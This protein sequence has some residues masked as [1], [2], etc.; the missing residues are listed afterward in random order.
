MSQPMSMLPTMPLDPAWLEQSAA[1]MHPDPRMAR[2]AMKLLFAAWRGSPAASVPNSQA[3]L[4]EVTGLPVELV[5]E[6]LESLT[7]GYELRGDGRLHHVGMARICEQMV[8]SYGPQIEAFS[9][10]LAMTAQDPEQF[11]L[12]SVEASR[13]ASKVKGKTRIP[14]DFGFEQNPELRVWCA[15]NGLA[16]PNQQ[17]YIMEKF[18]DDA[19]S[20]AFMYKDW[21]GAFRN[22]ARNETVAYSRGIPAPVWAEGDPRGL[23][24]ESPLR[25]VRPNG[26]PGGF[27]NN[28][29]RSPSRHEL[30]TAHNMM[31]PERYRPAGG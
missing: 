20:K 14:K 9:V 1:F 17:R 15:A 16:A 29:L 3:Y 27:A 2:G 28:G 22:Y 12:V 7:D 31:P 10:A 26:V 8:E 11:S 5:A 4:A 25:I 21:S 19:A 6:R 13:K 23:Q 18:C 30:A 24:L